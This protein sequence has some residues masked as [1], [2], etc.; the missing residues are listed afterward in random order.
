MRH[1]GRVE[2]TLIAVLAVCAAQAQMPRIGD[3]NFY[4]LHQTTADQVL[5]AARLAPGD[6]IS[7]SRVEL[8]DRIA[9]LPGVVAANVQTVCCQGDRA[10]LFIGI[11]E[12]EQP[13]LEWHAAPSGSD[14]ALPPEVMTWY[15][16]YQGALTRSELSGTP[17]DAAAVKRGQEHFQVYAATH[18]TRLRTT[19][20][21]SP[22]A[23]ERA[24][25]ATIIPYTANKAAA[26]PDLVFALED[27]DDGVRLSAAR[28][29][30][31]LAA[32]ARRQPALGIRIPPD[33]LVG[34]LSSV[35]LSDRVEA[36]KAL[37]AL[38]EH[39]NPAAL[40]RIRKQ[41]AGSLAEM[42][43]WKTD[44][45]AQP[46][47]R[48]LARAAA[49]RPSKRIRPGNPESAKA[50]SNR[51]CCPPRRSSSAKRWRAGVPGNTG[52]VTRE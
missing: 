30:G 34:L 7:A 28:A 4:G 45:F 52:P 11:Q 42:A 25:A 44:A 16:E 48:L 27:P 24:A 9:D 13:S 31:S 46:P 12:R 39:S 41:A 17:P 35:V 33:G 18:T 19:L 23:D 26:V 3:I 21:G 36:T 20:R 32:V 2:K 1:P 37:L 49:Y 6:P 8:E 43:R 14:A 22:D 5:L 29:L 51:R 50:S 47:F 15:R 38:T 40:A 10:A